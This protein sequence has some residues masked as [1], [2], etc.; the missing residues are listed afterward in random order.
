MHPT[1]PCTNVQQGRLNSLTF[2]FRLVWSD[3]PGP[4]PSTRENERGKE[5]KK[6]VVSSSGKVGK[7]QRKKEKFE[8]SWVNS[9]DHCFWC[10]IFS[11]T[12]IITIKSSEELMCLYS[13]FLLNT[14]DYHAMLISVS[15]SSSCSCFF[16]S[17]A[18]PSQISISIY[19]DIYI[20][21]Y[22]YKPHRFL[23]SLLQRCL[24]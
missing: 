13:N 17:G 10:Y 1:S 23:F 4:I 15:S 19:T 24:N 3:L 9:Y 18:T 21:T 20:Y 8:F 5:K 12:I 6:D 2:C 22:T 11:A 16:F 14:L 7:W